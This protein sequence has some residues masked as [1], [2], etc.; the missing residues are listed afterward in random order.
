VRAVRLSH[1]ISVPLPFEEAV[2]CFTP[3][4]ERAWIDGWDPVYPAGREAVGEDGDEPDGVWLTAG[5]T[6]VVTDRT[7]G[8][9]RYARV[10]SGVSAGTVTV[11]CRPDGER[12]A[13][14]VTYALTAL[15]D[16]G[17]ERL[18]ELAG[19]FPQHIDEWARAIAGR[20]LP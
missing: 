5:T 20:L 16:E 10:E 13:V 11:D 9:R 2:R 19:A 18:E 12:T 4:G 15:S 14:E 7:E 1:T 3:E 17:A 6:W 8:R